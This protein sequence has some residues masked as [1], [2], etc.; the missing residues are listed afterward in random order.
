M[1]KYWGK[2]NFFLRS[3][4]EADQKQKT[5][6]EKKRGLND[7]NNNGQLRITNATLGGAHKTAWANL[8]IGDLMVLIL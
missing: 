4:P 3:F 7:V 8:V 6:R 1:P 2:Q 5:E